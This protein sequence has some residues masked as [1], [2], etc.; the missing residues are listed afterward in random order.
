MFDLIEHLENPVQYL[1]RLKK[2]LNSGGKILIFTPN[3]DSFAISYAKENSNLIT[4]FEHLI[5][6]NKKS[7]ERLANKIGMKVDWYET[8]GLDMGDLSAYFE[9]IGEKKMAKMCKDSADIIQ[10]MLDN[11]GFSNHMRFMLS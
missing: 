1:L 9:W 7:I 4:P 8:R 11:I 2:H 10:P 6:F 3:F 5:Y